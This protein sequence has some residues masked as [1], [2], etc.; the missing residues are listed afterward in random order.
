M[1]LKWFSKK[2]QTGVGS[3]LEGFTLVELLVVIFVMTLIAAVGGDVLISTFRSSNKANII[4]EINQNANFVMSSVESVARN[5]K[6]AYS[7]A[8]NL[9]IID[10]YNGRNEFSFGAVSG[11]NAVLKALNGGSSFPL[12][13]TN[14]Q[15]GVNVVTASSSFTVTPNLSNCTVK[16]PLIN[17]S[18][19]LEQAPSAAGRIDY[20]AMSTFI[21]SI[22]IRNY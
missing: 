13:N 9:V 19:T 4:N 12:T 11:V 21:K 2:A 7:S 22:E 1:S 15:N 16:N 5:A 3:Q 18:L 17:I 6:C 10:Q 8:G 20:K 14:S